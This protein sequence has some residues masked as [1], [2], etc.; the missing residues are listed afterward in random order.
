[1][2]KS[3]GQFS[4]DHLVVE[5]AIVNGAARLRWRPLPGPISYHVEWLDRGGDW[6]MLWLLEGEDL[7][8]N[9]GGFVEYSDDC[10]GPMGPAGTYRVSAY[11]DLSCEDGITSEPVSIAPAKSAR[12]MKDDLL[13][14]LGRRRLPEPM[15]AMLSRL[16]W[17]R[18][19]WRMLLPADAGKCLGK[20]IK[21][22]VLSP[23]V[24]DGILDLLGAIL[25]GLPKIAARAERAFDEHGGPDVLEDGHQLDRPR[26]LIDSETRAEGSPGAWAM[27]VEIKGSDYAWHVEFTRT[28]FK[29]IWSGD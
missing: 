4:P 22:D 23:A 26:I 16:K 7:E 5:G 10:P 17:S 3:K 12:A 20:R 25:A 21:V 14:R 15:K 24:G 28:R 29:G 13:L 11:R 6:Y 27:I 18:Y 1:M 2:S 8:P 9:S 19:G